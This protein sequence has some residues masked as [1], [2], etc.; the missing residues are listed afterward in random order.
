MKN[1]LKVGSVIFALTLAWKSAFA[2][3]MFAYSCNSVEIAGNVLSLGQS[4]ESVA[5]A[6]LEISQEM[7]SLDGPGALFGGGFLPRNPGAPS[8]GLTVAIVSIIR[9]NPGSLGFDHLTG[10][11]DVGYDGSFLARTCNFA[12]SEPPGRS[13][14][15]DVPEPSAILLFATAVIVAALA[16]QERISRT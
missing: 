6:N 1:S 11:P 12:A 9:S 14:S 7:I 13:A 15:A 8:R 16:K 3:S 4:E 2:D 10:L 5:R